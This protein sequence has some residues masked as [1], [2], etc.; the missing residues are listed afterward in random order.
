[1]TIGLPVDPEPQ[2]RHAYHLYTI[3]VDEEKFSISRAAFLN[4]M[5]PHNIGVAVHYLSI[6]EHS[7]YQK[8]FD[9]QQ[10]DYPNT[11]RKGRQTVSLPLS[12]KWTDEDMGVSLKQ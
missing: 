9:W 10:E 4:F 12:A 11:M 6:P 3:G 8:T 7:Y 2:T 5:T 1:M